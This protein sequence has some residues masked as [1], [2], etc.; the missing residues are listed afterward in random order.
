MLITS[1]W[2][3]E[4]SNLSNHYLFMTPIYD[5]TLS[6]IS[7]YS[8]LIQIIGLGVGCMSYLLLSIGMLNLLLYSL[9]A[10]C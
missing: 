3:N 10:I 5:S 1:W 6:Y 2:L 8:P 4:C 9:S 7:I